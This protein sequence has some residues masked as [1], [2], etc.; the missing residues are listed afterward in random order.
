MTYAPHLRIA[1]LATLISACMALSFDAAF[2]ADEI[3][4]DA[5]RPRANIPFA[6][7]TPRVTAELDDPAWKNAV[8]LSNFSMALGPEA[9]GLTPYTTD[10]YMLWDSDNFYL[11]YICQDSELYLPLTGRRDL[12]IYQ[13][14]A[15]EIFFDPKGD[16]REYIEI[17]V[18]AKNDI[19]DQ[20][21]FVVT[22]PK[23]RESLVL[24]GEIIDR[25]FWWTPEWNVYFMR[26]A[27]SIQQQDGK[28]VGWVVDIDIPAFWTLR[29]LGLRTFQPDLTM[30]ANLVRC[31]YPVP[32]DPHG[33]R[34]LTPM[35]WA[36]TV[37]GV[38]HVSAAAMGY[39]TLLPPPPDYV[40]PK[41]AQKQPWE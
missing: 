8:H 2:C 39:I 14:D 25:D 35:S 37:Y 15:V 17:Q 22:E 13:G 26:T 40:P 11:R 6:T 4:N 24:E 30:R 9:E 31:E 7:V 1:V 34:K 21:C 23:Y 16:G 5:P 3:I 18:N 10:A 19:Y 27:A 33:K 41:A 36:P 28:P 20:L 29:R 38:P 32:D 12:E